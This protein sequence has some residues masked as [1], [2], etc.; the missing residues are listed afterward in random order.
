M[1]PERYEQKAGRQQE[2]KSQ[3]EQ[4]FIP[5]DIGEV[6]YKSSLYHRGS[7]DEQC[8]WDEGSEE[9]TIVDGFG[10]GLHEPRLRLWIKMFGFP[11]CPYGDQ[12]S[13]QHDCSHEVAHNRPPDSD[14]GEHSDQWHDRPSSHEG[15]YNSKTHTIP[16]EYSPL[17]I[18]V[19]ELR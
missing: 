5:E 9:N 13:K 15:P 12:C 11:Y 14:I 6:V 16:G 8:P 7:C 10:I 19:G 18:V 1:H 2:D 4:P 17:I 3:L